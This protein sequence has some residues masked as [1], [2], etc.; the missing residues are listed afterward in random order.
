[1]D[2]KLYKEFSEI[3][4]SHWWFKGRMKILESI[5]EKFLGGKGNGGQMQILDVGCGTAS[6]FRILE[7]YGNVSGTESSQEVIDELKNKGLKNTFFRA[8]LP[9]MKLG[10][11]FDCITAFEIL[12]HI[13]EDKKA[14]VDIYAHLN[15][16]GLLIGTVPAFKWLWS[17]HDELAH[18]KRRYTGYELKNKLEEA[19]FKVMKISYYN[20][21][22]FPI[23]APVRL[24]K[25]T[26][27]KNVVPISD[28]KAT[29]GP[30][31][32]IFE[33]VFAFERHWLKRFNF[34]LGFSLLFVASK[35]LHG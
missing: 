17:R 2:S 4:E 23:A 28:F 14:V 1:M 35:K 33:N 13:E 21:F 34:P 5:F 18:H 32:K 12:E 22:L 29:A 9:G 6:Y 30:F 19:G 20:T 10:R 26:I 3:N 8:E 25:K 24:L 31:D 7:K 11:A 27:L 15:N 16:G